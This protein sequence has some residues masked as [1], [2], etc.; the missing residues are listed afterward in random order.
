MFGSN[1]YCQFALWRIYSHKK[2]TTRFCVPARRIIRR[3]NT[4]LFMRPFQTPARLGT[5]LLLASPLKVKV[6]SGASILLGAALLTG[7]FCGADANAQGL[8]LDPT[9]TTYAGT[10]S[11]T[12][13]NNGNGGAATAA[14]LNNPEGIAYDSRGNTYIADYNNNTIRI[15]NSAG[16]INA[17]AGTGAACPA[18]ANAACGDGGAASAALFDHPTAMQFDTQGDLYI[19][20]YDADRVRKIT[21]TNGVITSASI[22]STVAGTG[23][24]GDAGNG[25]LATAATLNGPHGLALDSAGDLWISDQL[26]CEIDYVP[27]TAQTITIGGVA[28]AL[29]AGHLY[30][31]AGTGTCAGG[32]SGTVGTTTQLNGN[33][34]VA[35]DSANNLYIGDYANGKV[36]K[37]VT[38]TGVISTIAG[39]AADAC[40]VTA[41]T[42][43]VAPA[44]K[45]ACGDG[46]AGT[47]AALYGPTGVYVDGAG[48]IIIGDA[49]GARVREIFGPNSKV[50]TPGDITTIAG[51]SQQC[52]NITQNTTFTDGA[53]N[54][55]ATPP[56]YGFENLN[57]PNCGDGGP[58]TQALVSFPI[59]ISVNPQG[60]I[61]YVD[62]YDNKIREI[63]ENI[64]FPP[65]NVGATSASQ[66]LDVQTTGA[67]TTTI[68]GVTSS[69]PQF[70]VAATTGC[71]L[72]AATATG[73]V[74]TTPIAFKPQYPGIQ[75]AV[76]NFTTNAGTFSYGVVGTGVAP[77]A[78]TSPGLLSTVAGTGVAGATNG[79]ATA[80]TLKAPVGSI[81]FDSQGDYFIADSGN[82]LVRKVT[83]AGA[84]ST[85]A[86]TGAAGYTGDN[87]QAAAATLNAPS[88]VAVDAAG[89]VYIADT[90]ND[91]VR[92]VSTAGV[93][94]TFITGLTAPSGLV[95]DPITQVLFIADTGS[96]TV[97]QYS[98]A[99]RS[100]TTVVGN[101]TACA[102]TTAACG[103][104]GAALAANLNKPT[105]VAF[106]VNGNLFIAD[107]GDNRI[108]EVNTSNGTITTVVGTGAAGYT[109]DGAAALSATLNNPS[110]LVFDASGDI[111]I[112]DQGNNVIRFV[113]G[114]T[115]NIS[116]LVGNGTACTTTPSPACGDGGPANVSALSAPRGVAL[117][118]LGNVYITET[119]TNRI[120]MSA[121]TGT[122]L[123][124]AATPAGTTEG[125]L[126]A[127]L[128]NIGNAALTLA[129]PT[130][131]T[132][133]SI[134]TPFTDGNTAT[135]PQLGTTSAS[136]SLASGTQC[137]YLVSFSP[138]TS[139]T[140]TG[141]LI[142]TDNSLYATGSKQTVVLAGTATAVVA[143]QAV[144]AAPNPATYGQTVTLTYTV[145]TGTGDP[146]ATGTVT[147]TVAGQTVTGTVTGGVATIP[148][149]GLP[150]GANQPVSC[151]YGGDTVYAA[152]TAATTV[153]VN[154][155]PASADTFTA[156]PTTQVVGSP[157]QLTFTVVVPVTTPVS[158]PTAAPTGTVTFTGPGGY[159]SGP[160]TVVNGVATVPT[161]TLPV[162]T[163]ET[164]TAV[165]TGD[166]NYAGTTLTTPVTITAAATTQTVTAAPNPSTFGQPVTLTYTI[167]TTTG[168][169]A[170][171][172]T[173]TCTVAGQTVT[174]T[175]TGGV[176]TI[177]VTGL[178]VGANQPVS[179]SYGGNGTYAPG[180]AATTVTVNKVPASADTFKAAPTTQVVGSPV[181][182]TF[183]VV[184]PVTTPVSNPTAAPTGT[185]TFTGPGG[186]NSGPITVVNGV[187]TVPTS[188]LPVGTNETLTAVYTG[189]GNYAGT[190]LTTPVTITAAATTQTV[191]AAPNPSTFGQPVTLTYTIPTTTGNPAA[192]GTVTCTVAGQ[193]VT[194][195]VTGGVAT[196]PVT[197]LPVGANQP[198]SCSYGGN[199]TYAPG[200]AATTVTVNKVPASADT[201]TAN[202][203]TQVVGSPVQLTFTVVVP[204]TTPVS[205]PTAA[206]T[207]TVTFTGPGGYNSGPITV[208]NGVATVPTSTL[209]VGTNETLTAVYTGDGNYAGTTLT[210]P[211]TIT[212]AATTQTVTAAPN[213]S[214]FGQ[215]VTLTYTIPT[216]TGNPA[217]TGTVTC[218]V[219]GQTVTGTVT[220]GV[221]TIPV[222][223]LPVGANQPVS[224]SYGGNGTYAPGTAATTVTVNK[225]PASADTF[226]AAP[227]TQVVGSPVQLTFTVVVPVTTPVSNPT[228]AP[229]GTVTFT[230]P[231]GYNSGPITVV[232]GVATVPTSTLPVGTNETLTAVY[233][234][235]GNYAG[236]TLTTPVT[237]TTA[238]T[239]QTVTVNPNPSV[240]GNPVN[241][242]YTVPTT[243]GN[244]P[245]TGTVTCTVAGQT[246]TGTVTGGV[247]TIPVSG[248]PV[249]ANPVSCTYSGNGTYAPGTAT[250][251]AT[252]NP[253]APISIITPVPS[254]P[255]CG[256]PVTLTDTLT[257]V[258]GS[259]F[260]GT[261]QFYY[262]VAGGTPVAI[263]PPV[264]VSP[265]GVAM[266]TTTA[267]PCVP[268]TITA[269]FTPTAN[270]TT[271]A[272][273]P[274]GP[275]TGGPVTVTVNPADFIITA[276]PPNQIVNPGDTT[277]YTVALSGANGVPFTSAVTLSATGLP[278][279]ATVTFGTTTYVPNLGPTPTTMTI[280][281]SPTQ[282]MLQH[283][284]GMNGIAYGLLLLPLLGVRRIRRKIRALPKGISYCLAALVLLGGLGAVTGCGGGYFG[285]APQTFTIT[286][287]GTSGTLNHST[288]VTLTVR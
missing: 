166:G 262:T 106:D 103:D 140:Y 5:S 99:T 4:M 148:V 10:G 167:P 122:K 186:Y 284:G 146:A 112:A 64:I 90:G 200:T 47:A 156:N 78:V 128:E 9:I 215:P 196:I 87:G 191:T 174:G 224:C 24:A 254:S 61:L 95:V 179:C 7:T 225:V 213:P 220:G 232:N 114:G 134:S 282:A 18:A 59:L 31:V 241:I 55:G 29:T 245:A 1:E 46:G 229:T 121:A 20:D 147:C 117:D 97:R 209:P 100:L 41:P 80:G 175:V 69:S 67:G 218:T 261:V 127:Q 136:G 271:G 126:T 243:A 212:A 217:A 192:T 66:N 111:Y 197:G 265:G 170:A 189:D 176:A 207:G 101:G 210:T 48:D 164:L 250:G 242:I 143:T 230:G 91:V 247:A 50:G 34:N 72:G 169:P 288:T 153:T 35:L 115:S 190:T 32:G 235:D 26:S 27:A 2:K 253:V 249:G 277:T 22:V 151:S 219:A 142:E 158:N 96:N 33:T 118:N 163:N 77:Q 70:T 109:G 98:T 181:Q 82:N 276:T 81:A 246:V 221:A 123:S 141:S 73:T 120:R 177:P 58:A 270:P 93:I 113:G 139:G 267:L 194:G 102:T 171:T 116:T 204:V 130:A 51:T 266:L 119:G 38:T 131:G 15:V 259:S 185:V 258:N 23:A 150:V 195:T 74:C 227:T 3:N 19:A 161:S 257:Q 172:G 231:G 251:T 137:T 188:T 159:N 205:N 202:P 199:G 256:A 157:V 216:T 283:S 108:R 248:L 198:V 40:P 168:N 88:A 125:P 85:F 6:R 272:P 43:G 240:Y 129:V 36:R 57:F 233:T 149:T 187:A 49:F 21:A 152:G 56:T 145:A 104:S 173:V 201:F 183:T 132:N 52:T 237:I 53:S 178:P 182:L 155:V 228:A 184:V 17:F 13:T 278:P 211:V 208:V 274:Y 281:T 79:T 162:G 94:T 226:K 165:Y 44:A 12:A 124:F 160:I 11:L 252:V 286:V 280:V 138:P 268:V 260:Y 42:T 83:A 65:T 287:T 110:S 133:P 234:G 285:P 193:T 8:L 107:S 45:P 236:T 275:V 223:G 54:L 273:S 60:N 62:Q 14:G 135:C 214:T 76:I 279:G 180:T 206:P 30:I 269:V 144:T 255:T 154:K 89:N 28:T 239:T 203:T 71:T 238:T 105:G 86:G 63:N 39:T 264:A 92:I 222:T 244:P 68:T 37:L 75:T 263:P 84:I 16:I 25:G